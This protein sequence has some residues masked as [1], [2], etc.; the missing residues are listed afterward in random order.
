MPDYW[1]LYLI[2][3]FLAYVVFLLLREKE[4]GAKHQISLHDLPLG[5]CL[6]SRE[7]KILWLDQLFITLTGTKAESGD[8]FGASFPE[9]W[10]KPGLYPWRERLL[11]VVAQE[12]RWQ[13]EEAML[14]LCQDLTEDIRALAGEKADRPVLL[15]A[16]LDNRAEVF[17]TVEEEQRPYVIGALERTLAEW[18]ENL[19]GFLYPLGESR[20]L[21]LLTQGQ[22]QRAEREQFSILDKI[23]AIKEGNTIP[24]TLSMGIGL[25]GQGQLGE[26]G[27][28]AQAALELAQERGGDQVVL[29][30]PEQVRFFGGKSLSQE[31]RTKV[32]TRLMAETLKEMILRSSQV[33]LMGHTMA[34]FDSMGACLALFKAV[35]DLGRQGWIVKDVRNPAAE[36]LLEL[37]PCGTEK[38]LL[39]AGEGWR[40]LQDKTML[41][42]VDTHKPSLLPEAG[43]LERMESIA[44]IDHH[45]R[46]EEFIER[47]D[48]V[49]LESYASSSCEL[50]A[51][52]LQYIG[53]P[54]K[55]GAEEASALLAGMTMDTKN[56]L[57]QTGARTFAA[58]S[59]LRKLGADP[60]AVRKL[61]KDD[62]RSVVQRAEVISKARI[63]YGE[64][65][66]SA[67]TER[68]EEA[69][70]LAAKAADAMLNINGVN[71]SFV[72]WP[73]GEGVVAISARSN[74]KFNVQVIME[75]LGGGGHL[76]VAAAQVPGTVEEVEEQLLNALEEV[77][78]KG[79]DTP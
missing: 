70:L 64:I 37:F 47:A 63:V 29:K 14:Y 39:P 28:L 25:A 11:N 32:K 77:F 65:A 20:Y 45:R 18:V 73:T 51:E 22:L 67:G 30:S 10:A 68:S 57:F 12:I 5:V 61:Q 2:I 74:G 43:L 46:G 50:V 56:F 1:L 48:L 62:L 35:R 75:G 58:A 42:V 34:D 15:L 40:K 33:M 59:Y 26:L 41:I 72:L 52:L 4:K 44:V 21:L 13:K 8:Q 23:R 55:L 7:G 60:A 49:Y 78:E 6:V 79:E 16:Q 3:I 17:K 31:K 24:L 9:Y 76:T 38:A 19:H 69:Q 54:V 53:E 27:R 71:G 36:R 66:L